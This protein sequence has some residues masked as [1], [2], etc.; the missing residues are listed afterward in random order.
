MP[1]SKPRIRRR[2]RSTKPCSRLL[3]ATAPR[4]AD[5]PQAL[6]DH[7]LLIVGVRFLAV[8]RPAQAV[9][10]ERVP[11]VMQRLVRER[12]QFSNGPRIA[13]QE[14]VVGLIAVDLEHLPV[15]VA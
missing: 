3:V 2:T 14:D 6:R 15:A 1:G 10:A 11:D 5:R 9:H 7:E 13:T 12:G 4:L 8:L